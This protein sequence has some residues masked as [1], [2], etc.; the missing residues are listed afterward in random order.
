MV[1]RYFKVV[2]DIVLDLRD[3]RI[4]SADDKKQMEGVDDMV[5]FGE[6]LRRAREDKGMTQQSLAEQ[7]YVTRQSVSRWECGDRYPDLLTTKKIS[8]ILDVSLDDL[9]SGKEMQK[10]VERNPVIEK[11]SANNVMIALYAFVVFSFLIT[12]VDI[13]IRF[14][15]QSS[16]A[17]DYSD[18]QLMVINILGIVIQIVFFAYG[19]F[20]AIR[21]TLSPK[22]MGAVV[23]AYFG[24]M[25]ITSS[26]NVAQYTTWQ[27]V[28]VGIVLMIP[29]I[30]GAIASFFYFIRCKNDKVWSC[31]ISVA[32]IWGIVRVIIRNYQMIRY[33]GQYLSMNTTLRLVLEMAIYGLILYQTFTLAKKRK[34]AIE[35]SDR[36]ND[37]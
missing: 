32:A 2:L 18:I 21:G 31:L 9:L 16:E 10:V 37:C 27:L 23:V 25:C 7:L 1:T 26:N 5:E 24:A 29:N 36:E 4:T 3:I 12:I 35:I 11:K 8:Q 34:N 17:L 33:A 19:L 20:Q 6:Q 14:P 22:R 15:I 28:S 30:I 13:I